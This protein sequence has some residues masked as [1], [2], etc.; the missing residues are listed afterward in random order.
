[1]WAACRFWWHPPLRAVRGPPLSPCR[2]DL[3][4]HANAAPAPSRAEYLFFVGRWSLVVGRGRE[5]LDL[6]GAIAC[7][8][9]GALFSPYDGPRH[10]YIGASAGCWAVFN[11]SVI[12]RDPDATDLV[13]RSRIPNTVASIPPSSGPASL[14]TLFGDAY[15]VQHHGEDSSQ[16]IQSVA[17][18]LLNLHGMIGGHTTAHGWALARALRVRGVFHKLEPPALGSALT[19]RYVVPDRLAG[20]DRFER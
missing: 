17:A 13:S 14:E 10:R 19:I 3:R 1:M 4:K 15:G 11:W 20:S 7:P 16:A 6:N 2:R 18:H 8:G 5:S 9:C 12:S